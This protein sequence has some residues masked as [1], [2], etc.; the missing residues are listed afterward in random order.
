MH[1][2]QFAVHVATRQDVAE[3]VRQVINESLPRL[4]GSLSPKELNEKFLEK[5]PDSLPHL[6]AGMCTDGGIALV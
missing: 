6:I 1:F 5:H 4:T 2:D 3:P